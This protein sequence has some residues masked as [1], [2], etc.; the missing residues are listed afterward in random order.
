MSMRYTND[1]G[2]GSWTECTHGTASTNDCRVISFEDGVTG[3]WT[4]SPRPPT[5]AE[6]GH[7][8]WDKLII[9]KYQ[10]CAIYAHWTGDNIISYGDGWKQYIIN[11]RLPCPSWS[12]DSNTN[13]YFLTE[14]SRKSH[15]IL[16]LVYFCD[17]RLMKPRS[18]A[19]QTVRSCNQRPY[20]NLEPPV[21][22]NCH[23]GC[24]GTNRTTPTSWW[25]LMQVSL[26]P[27]MNERSNSRAYNNLGL[28]PAR[29]GRKVQILPARR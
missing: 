6:D 29:H 20:I 16:N 26:E 13:W 12:D 1:V 4:L 28:E 7:Q 27:G 22:Y 24:S 18:V 23:V 9:Y 3:V 25:R 19:I 2:A 10:S 11:Y 14:P 17:T 21:N 15:A 5:N 8:F